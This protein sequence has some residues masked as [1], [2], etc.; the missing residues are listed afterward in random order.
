MINY[1]TRHAGLDPV[2]A[3][4]PIPTSEADPESSSG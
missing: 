1:V 2:S 4:V 3:F